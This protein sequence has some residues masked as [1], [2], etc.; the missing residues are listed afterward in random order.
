MISKKLILFIVLAIITIMLTSFVQNYYKKPVVFVI[1]EENQPFPIYS[2]V[3]DHE[4]TL[5]ITLSS[6]DG[7]LVLKYQDWDVYAER[8]LTLGNNEFT[9]STDEAELIL[10]TGTSAEGSFQIID[11]GRENTLILM[12]FGLPII[13]AVLIILTVIIIRNRSKFKIF[14]SNE[15][16]N[17]KFIYK[18]GLLLVDLTIL[19]PLIGYRNMLPYIF[20]F[21]LILDNPPHIELLVDFSL[22][23]IYLYPLIILGVNLTGIFF[24]LRNKLN[25][26]SFLN[27]VRYFLIVIGLLTIITA[28][29][30][31]NDSGIFVGKFLLTDY[32]YLLTY[33]MLFTGGTLISEHA[34]RELRHQ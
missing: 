23:T 8:N 17:D 31:M 9:I 4:V 3:G 26:Q 10:I 15:S 28:L 20:N 29:L 18:F 24:L 30:A 13:F 22:I 32:V 16:E 1:S 34:I 25:N 7:L 27:F 21:L 19:L 2:P 11:H 12:M 6:T 14:F 33:G 5:I